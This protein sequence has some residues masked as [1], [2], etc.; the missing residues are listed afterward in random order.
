MKQAFKRTRRAE[1]DATRR[2]TLPRRARLPVR[3][4]TCSSDRVQ[5]LKSPPDSHLQRS[6]SRSA[7]C[8]GARWD[9]PNLPGERR[10][11]ARIRSDL[12]LVDAAPWALERPERQSVRTRQ[13]AQQLRPT[14]TDRCW[15]HKN[16]SHVVCNCV[17]ARPSA[18]DQ[19]RPVHPDHPRPPTVSPRHT[20]RVV[21]RPRDQALRGLLVSMGRGPHP[22]PHT[23]RARSTR[24]RH[25]QSRRVTR[26]ATTGRQ[27]PS[28]SHGPPAFG[29]VHGR[30]VV[31][32]FAAFSTAQPAQYSLR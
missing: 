8:T 26:P 17:G 24:R 15:R 20:S 16:G 6:G 19:E 9:M 12:R 5:S 2:V 3:D 25:Y 4:G 31:P 22:H 29:V 10:S 1:R 14:A 21:V 30:E 27:E 7:L 11:R 32:A 23:P 28:H 18:P 13:C